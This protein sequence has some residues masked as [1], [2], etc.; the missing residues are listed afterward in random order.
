[1]GTWHLPVV[2]GPDGGGLGPVRSPIS[3]N[4]KE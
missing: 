4:P 3:A 2:G 1:M